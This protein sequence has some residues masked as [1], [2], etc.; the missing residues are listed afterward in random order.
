MSSRD[1]L[2]LWLQTFSEWNQDKASRLA[3][4]LAY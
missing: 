1:L 4:A 3:A 2:A